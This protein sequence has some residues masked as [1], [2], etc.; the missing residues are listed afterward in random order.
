M[1][2]RRNLALYN[3]V[4]WGVLF[5]ETQPD[6]LYGFSEEVREQIHADLS[7]TLKEKD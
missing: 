6:L 2:L 1:N 7:E 5:G 3:R 4:V